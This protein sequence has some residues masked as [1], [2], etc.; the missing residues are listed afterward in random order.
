MEVLS[1]PP[2]WGRR[3][4]ARLHA[5][6]AVADAALGRLRANRWPLVGAPAGL[7]TDATVAG[8]QPACSDYLK[9]M[10]APHWGLEALLGLELRE[11]AVTRAAEGDECVYVWLFAWWRVAVCVVHSQVVG[12]AALAALAVSL[13]ALF[14]EALPGCGVASA[15]ALPCFGLAL[16]VGCATVRADGVALHGAGAVPAVPHPHD[17][18]GVS[19]PV[20]W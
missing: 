11:P 10:E 14:G 20:G 12:A 19:A 9:G 1:S 18:Q 16:A 4:L 8:D 6:R 5:R 17:R 2:S 13:D 15:C 7:G 3:D